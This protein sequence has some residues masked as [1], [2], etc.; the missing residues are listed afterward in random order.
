MAKTRQERLVIANSPKRRPYAARFSLVLEKTIKFQIDGECTFLVDRNI[1]VRVKPATE[2]AT[3]RDQ[4][5][6]DISI[7][8]FTTAGQAESEGLRIVLG[9]LW[10]AVKGHYAVRLS[11]KTPLPC[12]VYLRT[13]GHGVRLFGQATLTISKGIG[14]IVGPVNAIAK[15]D[16][17]IDSKLLLAME[18]FTSA[19]LETTERSKY[20]GLIS[21]LE[22]LAIQGKYGNAQLEQLIRE[23]LETLNKIE[24]DTE[25][26]ASIRGRIEGLRQESISSSIKNLVRTLL[27]EDTDAIEIIEDA[28]RIRSKMLHEG[29][30]DAD[31]KEKGQQVEDVIRKVIQKRIDELIQCA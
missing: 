10:A 6:W 9:F 17:Q 3:N 28:Y 25:A 7:E 13:E 5:T 30:T 18:L 31:L 8:G 19:R 29:S 1:I 4:Q 27:P 24:L 23:A 26:K 21:S 16:A 15:S 20:L 11:Y 22:P 14:N 12:E 2:D